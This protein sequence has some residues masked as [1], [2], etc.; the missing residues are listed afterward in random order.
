MVS[1]FRSL[2]LLALQGLLVFSSSSSA[3][4]TEFGLPSLSGAFS[5]LAFSHLPDGRYL[6]GEG[7]RFYAQDVWGGA[8]YSEFANVPGSIDP[9]FIAVSSSSQAVAGGGGFGSSPLYTFDPGNLATPA[10]AATSFTIQNYQGVFKD[11]SSLY[12]AGLYSG[13]THGVS[14]VTLDG[15]VNKVILTNVSTFSAGF[16]I[17][18]L[19]NLYV[20][21][22]DDGKVYR[23]TDAQLSGAISGT[24][25]SLADGQL[26]YDFGDGGHI[27]TI[28]VDAL[29]RLWAAGYLS[30]GLRVYDPNLGQEA[31][32][33]P[34]L[35]NANYSVSTF[36]RDGQSY[37]S[38]VNQA[39]P[40][41]GGTAMAYGYELANTLVVP[42]PAAGILV[43]LGG[44]GL[45]GLGW[46]R[47]AHA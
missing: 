17:D 45:M 31:T 19:G 13:F 10:F 22:T 11:S 34:G 26:I 39:N 24:P 47:R 20:G 9:S 27:G 14:Y 29:G 2:F 7:N 16:T 35:D 15:S 8:A 32:Y 46:K 30:N 23:F 41:V 28:A 33:V 37:V 38:Y 1:S 36:S 44:A 18:A 25:L 42:E 43:L 40:F 21:D 4:W 6:Y 3:A 12:V 5:P